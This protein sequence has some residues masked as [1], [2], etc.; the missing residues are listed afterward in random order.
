MLVERAATPAAR[1][2]SCAPCDANVVAR[3]TLGSVKE[4]VQWA[5]VEQDPMKIDSRRWDAK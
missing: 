5:F 3:C 4:V 1:W 2:A